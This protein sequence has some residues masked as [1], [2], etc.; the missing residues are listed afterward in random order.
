MK[1]RIYLIVS[2]FFTFLFSIYTMLRADQI[3]AS[4]IEGIKETYESYPDLSERVLH[5]LE[6]NG[7]TYLVVIS[8]LA[9][10][11][12]LFFMIYA[13]RESHILKRK[14]LLIGLSILGIFLSGISIMEGF[15]LGNVIVL[16]FS[17]RKSEEDYLEKKEIPVLEPMKV[18]KKKIIQSVILLV[19]YFSQF[20]W[21]RWLPEAFDARIAIQIAFDIVV[22]ILAIW[23][24]FDELKRD[25]LAWKGN[26]SAYLRYIFSKYGIGLLIYFG[27]IALS[28][29]LVGSS[30]TINQQ[31]VES[32]P[33]WYVIPASVLW[34]PIVEEILFRG[35]IRRFIKKDSLFIL[36]S[37]FVFGILHTYREDGL[38]RIL[39]MSMPYATLGAIFAYAYVKT[40]NLTCNMGMHAL[41]NAIGTIAR[42]FI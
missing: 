11:I 17:R 26:V 36:V 40:E 25:V 24:F 3:L 38:M 27:M 15:F 39:V 9:L 22:L 29:S 8:C 35:V 30:T 19:V 28:F 42:L 2:S 14:G 10:L 6:N 37:A 32:L 31:T 18:D 33:W 16:L 7:H 23:F 20:V 4:S 34:A 5:L 13:I 41:H 12:S 1:K 21:V